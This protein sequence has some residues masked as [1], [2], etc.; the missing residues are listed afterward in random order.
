MAKVKLL[1]TGES[2]ITIN[3]MKGDEV[4]STT[5]PGAKQNPEDRKKLIPG[6][7]EIEDSILDAALKRQVVAYYFEEGI[8]RRA[9]GERRSKPEPSGDGK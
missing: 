6:E 3:V 2:D 1:N 9:A 7:G 4:V 8:L 5:I